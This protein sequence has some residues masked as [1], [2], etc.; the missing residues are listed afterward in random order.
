MTYSIQH[1]CPDYDDDECNYDWECNCECF[2]FAGLCSYDTPILID[3]AGDG[4]DLTDPSGGVNFDLDSDGVARRL[5]WTSTA[6]DDGFLALDRN[7]NNAIDDGSEL[8]G[9]RSP[10][11]PSAQPNGFRA[12][13][14]YDKAAHGGNADGRIDE[15]DTIFSSLRLWQDTNRN[16]ASESSELHTLASLGV[17]AIDLNYKES[18]R[19]DSFGNQFRYRAKVYDSHGAHVG[20][21][22][23]DVSLVSAP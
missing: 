9:N 3:I 14:E 6:S 20:R 18:R 8:F 11:S 7:G 21:W 10:Q 16:G 22:A 4:F 12:L 15:R 17:N 5:A 1:S 2:C 13:A 19:I 23:W